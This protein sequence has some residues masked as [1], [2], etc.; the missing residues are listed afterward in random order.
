VSGLEVSTRFMARARVTLTEEEYKKLKSLAIRVVESGAGTL[1]VGRWWLAVLRLERIVAKDYETVETEKK[2][3]EPK[4]VDFATEE[5]KCMDFD[6]DYYEDIRLHITY[7]CYWYRWVGT[8]VGSID[9][10]DI[11]LYEDYVLEVLTRSLAED[12]FSSLLRP[13]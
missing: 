11:N 7:L 10:K 9:P 2:L 5:E 1:L 8:L 4:P 12:R 3:E 13:M 6:I